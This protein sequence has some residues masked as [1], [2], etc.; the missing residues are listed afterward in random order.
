MAAAIVATWWWLGAPVALP[1][2]PLGVGEKLYCMSYSPFR[3]RQTPFDRTLRIDPGQIEDDLARLAAVTDCVRTYST[4]LGLDQV[5]GI[6]ERHGLKV[7]QGIWLGRERERNRVEIETAIALAARYPGTVRA[8]VA[9]NEVLLRGELSAADLAG[10]IQEVKARVAV[11]VTYAEVWEFWL[12]NR[13]VADSV[14]FVTIHILPYWEDIP[15]PA[16]Q[17]ASH[18]A[19]L[20]RMMAAAFPGKEILLGEVGWPSAGRMREGALPSPV[21]QARVI[22]DVL[23]VAKRDGFHANVIE[24]FDQPWKRQLEGTVGGHWG[25]LSGQSRAPKFAW[26]VPLSNHPDWPWQAAVGV[27]LAAVILVAAAAAS[28][29]SKAPPTRKQWFGI[30]AMALVPGVLIG[31]AFANVPLESLGLGG[32]THSLVMLAVGL[33]SPVA[34]AAA[35]T[36]N[37]PVP[38]FSEVIGPRKNEAPSRAG[39]AFGISWV[40]LCAVAAEVALGLAFDP[41]YRDFPFAPL[42]AAAAPF[43]I[44]T[45][46]GAAARRREL[47]EIVMA[48]VLAASSLYIVWNE[49]PANW[50]SLSLCGVFAAIVIAL[51]RPRAEPSS[52]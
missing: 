9:G 12:R 27:L 46:V 39:L 10:L 23:A 1:A 40:V 30:A 19:D 22:E 32:W 34:G 44:L 2:S 4:D 37:V 21:N 17:A 18:V 38:S 36:R 50:Q 48:A 26:G 5:A 6:A 15:I 13:P 25:L 28:R 24:A 20:R 11:P 49:G 41:R 14:D 35:L 31:W 42:G 52:K 7:I 16:D 43:L 51:L 29:T 33:T 47:A 45:F 8:F 3:G